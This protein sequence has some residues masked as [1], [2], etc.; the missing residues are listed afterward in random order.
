MYYM[1]CTA[2]AGDNNNNDIKDITVF[3]PERITQ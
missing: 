1:Y 3:I 2:S